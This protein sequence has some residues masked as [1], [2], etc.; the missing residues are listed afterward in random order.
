MA[1]YGTSQLH[2]RNTVPVAA[3]ELLTSL[4][5]GPKHIVLDLAAMQ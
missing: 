1:W 5:P 3:V 2:S 4:L